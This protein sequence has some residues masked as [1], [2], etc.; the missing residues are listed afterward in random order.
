MP[1]TGSGISSGGSSTGIIFM[2][3][4][5]MLALAVFVGIRRR[6]HL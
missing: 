1:G 3:G 2:A 4:F 5:L 6:T